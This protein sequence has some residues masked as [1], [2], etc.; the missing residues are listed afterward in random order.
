MFNRLS[1]R[2]N[3]LLG[4]APTDTPAAVTPLQFA[5]KVPLDSLRDRPELFAEGNRAFALSVGYETGSGRKA[6][7]M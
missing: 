7:R 2:L 5:P 6:S 1:A 4:A 3:L